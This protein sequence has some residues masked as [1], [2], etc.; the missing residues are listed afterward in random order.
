MKIPSP[1]KSAS[2]PRAYFHKKRA[3]GVIEPNVRNNPLPVLPSAFVPSARPKSP[4]HSENWQN[5]PGAKWVISIAKAA[6]C[7]T[8]FTSSLERSSPERALHL[9]TFPFACPELFGLAS[10]HFSSYIRHVTT[11]FPATACHIVPSKL[12]KQPRNDKQPQ[13]N[14]VPESTGTEVKFVRPKP[15][16]KHRVAQHSRQSPASKTWGGEASGPFTGR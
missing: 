12:I 5:R 4:N 6:D 8:F 1:G 13:S 9:F 10:F 3:K 2:P 16:A 15:T 11:T 14:E 7:Q